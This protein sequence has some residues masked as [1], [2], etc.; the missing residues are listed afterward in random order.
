MI[1]LYHK[2]D[3]LYGGN[4]SRGTLAFFVVDFTPYGIFGR[5]SPSFIVIYSVFVREWKFFFS[6]YCIANLHLQIGEN[7]V[8]GIQKRIGKNSSRKNDQELNF[9]WL[10]VFTV[11]LTT[12]IVFVLAILLDRALCT[13]FVI[14]GKQNG[15][16]RTKRRKHRSFYGTKR[17]K[18]SS[19]Y[20]RTGAVVR[21]TADKG[22][23]VTD[24]IHTLPTYWHTHTYTLSF[25]SHTPIH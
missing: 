24:H 11:L 14:R 9:K 22:R 25:V 15:E 20:F 2:K 17:R 3:N 5:P 23:D 1:R 8:H 4:I 13:L 19:F 7:S 16:R 10:S 21:T 18:Q 6:N 12:I